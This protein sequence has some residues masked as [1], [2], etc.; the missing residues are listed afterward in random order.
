[1]ANI[2]IGKIVPVFKGEWN[3][4]TTYYKLD[5]VKY[6]GSSYA[7]IGEPCINVVPSSD[8]SKWVLVA[9][10]GDKGV[11]DKNTVGSCTLD[12]LDSFGEKYSA[13]LYGYLPTVYEVR[14]GNFL[15]GNL[16][17]IADNMGHQLTQIITTHCSN[18]NDGFNAHTDT[19]IYTYYRSYNINS[20]H[21]TN[22]R[23]T[24]SEWK[25]ISNLDCIVGNNNYKDF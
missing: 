15:V 2:I 7:C 9:Q 10:K 5:V 16:T 4:N 14:K 18:A 17:V 19:A 8:T 23:G 6:E 1:M 13:F 20:P 22:A 24:W 21:L 25:C 12:E 11:A 3:K